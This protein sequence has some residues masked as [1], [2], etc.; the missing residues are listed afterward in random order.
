MSKDWKGWRVGGRLESE[1]LDK[2]NKEWR[3]LTIRYASQFDSCED[4]DAIRE[5]LWS[6]WLGIGMPG[7]LLS[8]KREVVIK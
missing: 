7:V 8:L 6:I 5:Q 1:F 2:R 3:V 4:G